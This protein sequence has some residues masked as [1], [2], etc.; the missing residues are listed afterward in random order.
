MVFRTLK[1]Y[2][3][4]HRWN[5]GNDELCI[6]SEFNYLGVVFNYDGRFTKHS[7]MVTYKALKTLNALM[8]NTG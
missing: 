6:V 7:R 2:N 4:P 1:V 5:Y 8:S 3:D